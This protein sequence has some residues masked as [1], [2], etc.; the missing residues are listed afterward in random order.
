MTDTEKRPGS[1]Q[2]DPEGTALGGVRAAMAEREWL[3]RMSGLV[4]S[5]VIAITI[6]SM[7]L[8]PATGM[9]TLS[10]LDKVYH[11][12]AFG[13]L[14]FP[15]IMTDSRRWAW[16]VPL[17]IAYGGAIE[18][19]Q[20]T[21]GRSAEWL[22]FGANTAGALAGAALAELLHDRI[23]ASV[24]Q[25]VPTVDP[26]AEHH[27]DEQRLEDM[28]ADLMNELRVVLREELASVRRPGREDPVGPSPAEDVTPPHAHEPG[29]AP[30]G[31]R[32]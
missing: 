23:R 22:D 31:L 26:S 9:V 12:V 10:G 6:A 7:T 3:W 21:V 24:F 5:A 30:P 1:S 27:S 15:L 28:R 17:V 13:A 29:A 18:L 8:T 25:S 11:F 20:P 19:I 2:A 32:H 14:V 16:A 4:L